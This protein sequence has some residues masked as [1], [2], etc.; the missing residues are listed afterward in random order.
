MI[1]SDNMH[2]A[3]SIVNKL[4]KVLSDNECEVGIADIHG[5]ILCCS[6]P[7]LVG[8]QQEPAIWAIAQQATISVDKNNM[9]LF[10]SA[11]RGVYI[12]FY[13]KKTLLGVVIL[14]GQTHALKPVASMAA[15]TAEALFDLEN[16]KSAYWGKLD[17]RNIFTRVLLYCEEDVYPMEVFNIAAKLH[18]D[19]DIVRIPLMFILRYNELSEEQLISEFQRNPLHNKEDIICITRGH[20]AVVFKAISSDCAA[21]LRDYRQ[22]VEE[23]VHQ[24]EALH[25]NG[26]HALICN[27]GTLQNKM[28]DYHKA[29]RHSLWVTNFASD[30][31]AEHNTQI[32]YFYDYVDRYL[33]SLINIEEYHQIFSVHYEVTA[34]KEWSNFLPYMRTLLENNMNVSASSAKLYLHRNTLLSWVNKLKIAFDLDPMNKE[35]DRS[36]LQQLIYFCTAQE[37]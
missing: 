5:H 7:E 11:R 16:Y 12:P 37:H 21:A 26:G 35:T 1:I 15:A 32:N 13:D 29:Y 24:A 22:T 23:Y 25:I 18:Y 34:R 20:N 17:Q 4:Q 19:P 27:V 14:L 6:R 30:V 28:L 33:Q 2:I 36:L 9:H 31:I 3:Q 10:H 8:S